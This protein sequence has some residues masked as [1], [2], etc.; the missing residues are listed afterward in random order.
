MKYRTTIASSLISSG[1]TTLFLKILPGD[2]L[3]WGIALL[4]I[5]IAV[6]FVKKSDDVSLPTN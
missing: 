6:L 5:G 4:A 2:S 1:I 3:W